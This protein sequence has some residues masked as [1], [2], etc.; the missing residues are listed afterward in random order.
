MLIRIQAH[1]LMFSPSSVG[2][3][4]TPA[5]TP[6]SSGTRR[7]LLVVGLVVLV[8]IGGVLWLRSRDGGEAFPSTVP[9]RSD[10]VQE[11]SAAT[12]AGAAEAVVEVPDQDRDNLSDAEEARAGTDP[13]K[14]D[15]DGDGVSDFEEVVL[16][17]S[18]PLKPSEALLHPSMQSVPSQP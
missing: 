9:V 13:T 2:T 1:K 10:A 17:A 6:E 16:R 8:S 3:F 4:E 11:P 18:D 5:P 15:T 14:S 7:G 12:P